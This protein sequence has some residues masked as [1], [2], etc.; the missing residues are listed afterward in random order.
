MS[1]DKEKTSTATPETEQGDAAPQAVVASPQVVMGPLVQALQQ[2]LSRVESAAGESD[3]T[4]MVHG[5]RKALKEYRALLRLVGGDVAATARRETAATARELAHAR[6]RAT[7]LEALEMLRQAGF[8]RED[9]LA[10][11]GEAIGADQADE[12]EHESMHRLLHQF[13]VDARQA[14]SSGL[15][16]KANAVDLVDGLRRGYRAAR[17]AELTTPEAMHEVRKRVVTHRYQMSFVADWFSGKGAKRAA[18]AQRLRDVLG[19]YQ[20]I[21]TLRPLLHSVGSELEDGVIARL[22]RAMARLQKRLG[23]QAHKRHAALFRRS[24]RSFARRLG[25]LDTPVSPLA[26][27]TAQTWK[28]LPLEEGGE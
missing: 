22:E 17:K 26:E 5:A 10:A 6:D 11:A 19:A 16:A 23:K 9:D 18:R 12:R 8:A 21:E 14:L 7:A 3:T 15:E 27:R 4:E 28:V 1:S 25:A 2:A 13:L 20:D 24:S